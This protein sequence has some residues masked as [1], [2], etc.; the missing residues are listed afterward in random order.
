MTV[1]CLFVRTTLRH[2]TNEG[3]IMTTTEIGE[4]EEVF[5]STQSR[6]LHRIDLE[7]PTC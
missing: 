1:C 5:Y 7:R 4:S 6:M 3:F 2:F